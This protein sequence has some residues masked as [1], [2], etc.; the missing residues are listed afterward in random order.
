MNSQPV[1]SV[2]APVSLKLK[3][4]FL[5]SDL[6][7][8]VWCCCWTQKHICRLQINSWW[9]WRLLHTVTY[10]LEWQ[11]P[12][13]QSTVWWR[14][15]W[16]CLHCHQISTN[17]RQTVFSTSIQTPDEEIISDYHQNQG[18]LDN[19][20]PLICHLS[21]LC[22]KSTLMFG[23]VLTFTLQFYCTLYDC[24]PSEHNN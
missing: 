15:W 14:G 5:H 2:F 1:F 3:H 8:P 20:F 18:I 12:H 10:L 19:F 22:M 7:C 13:P 21:P 4:Y 6:I 9:W 17:G 23:I 24:M 11:Y 16:W